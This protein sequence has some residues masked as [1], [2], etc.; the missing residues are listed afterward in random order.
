MWIWLLKLQLGTMAFETARPWVQDRRD[1]LSKEPIVEAS[2]MDLG[3][4]HSL[5]DTLKV[6][7]PQYAPNPLGTVL[8]FPRSHR[9]FFYADN[10]FRHPASKLDHNYAASCICFHGRCWIALFDDGR[11]VTQTLDLDLMNE[12][13]A[14]GRDPVTFYPELMYHRS[15]FDY[16]PRS[17]VLSPTGEPATGIIFIPPMSKVPVLDHDEGVLDIYRQ[18]LLDRVVMVEGD[19]E[20]PAS[21]E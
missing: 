14:E 10:M 17:L 5:F 7:D 4:L 20:G 2:T 13:V 19:P 18:N 8:S 11:N 16:M 3:F 9:D 12:A 15:R 6:D 1:P 21:A